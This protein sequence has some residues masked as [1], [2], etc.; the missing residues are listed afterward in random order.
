M[1]LKIVFSIKLERVFFERELKHPFL[2]DGWYWEGFFR[3]ILCMRRIQYQ[4]L[5]PV[6]CLCKDSRREL[7]FYGGLHVLCS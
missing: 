2:V 5:P 7:C 3:R 6:G 1:C 4:P